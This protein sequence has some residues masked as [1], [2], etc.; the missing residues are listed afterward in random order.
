MLC[1]S[2]VT[3]PMALR[4]LRSGVN[5]RACAVTG[6][7]DATG[8]HWVSP[9]CPRGH[10]VPGFVPSCPVIALAIRTSCSPPMG[11][12]S[13]SFKLRA[14]VI[15]LIIRFRIVTLRSG[16]A[17]LY[18]ASLM[19]SPLYPRPVKFKPIA[20]NPASSLVKMAYRPFTLG[21]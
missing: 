15:V 3:A 14:L 20:L 8:Y 6:T 9:G 4:S 1:A 2:S 13:V 17:Y 16:G 12:L 18:I 10:F 21:R 5:D 11:K 19:V 7:T